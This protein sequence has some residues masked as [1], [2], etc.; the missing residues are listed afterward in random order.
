[1]SP[2]VEILL[3]FLTFIPLSI[4]QKIIKLWHMISIWFELLCRLSI[5]I[6]NSDQ[7]IAKLGKCELECLLIIYSNSKFIVTCKDAGFEC[8][9]I[10][11]HTKEK[12]LK[13]YF[14][15]LV[16]PFFLF[17]I[18]KKWKKIVILSFLV[19]KS[20][21]ETIRCASKWFVVTQRTQALQLV[22]LLSVT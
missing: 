19:S 20:L 1:M 5:N 6:L 15:H 18:K 10:R 7:W 3:A 2:D 22:N 17:L 21:D 8:P 4:L 14:W 9:Y 16:R 12:R 11:T 13:Y